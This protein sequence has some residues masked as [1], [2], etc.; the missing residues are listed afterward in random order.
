MKTCHWCGDIHGPTQLCHRAQRGLTRRSFGFLF[1][2]GFWGA[3]AAH[4]IHWPFDPQT[5]VDF[6]RKY[7]RDCMANGH[8]PAFLTLPR[9][10][11]QRLMT[12][13]PALGKPT[14]DMELA[15][16]KLIVPGSRLVNI[17]PAKDGMVHSTDYKWP[18]RGDNKTPII[19][20]K[21]VGE[22]TVPVRK[23]FDTA[24]RAIKWDDD[25][26]LGDPSFK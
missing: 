24:A 10:M 23:E 12:E 17:Y 20:S 14:R 25:A 13:L 15:F 19:A 2:A 22:S 4:A 9:P 21:C 11:Y 6:C 16:Q 18:S 8:N 26:R 5:M 3:T 1:A 7:V